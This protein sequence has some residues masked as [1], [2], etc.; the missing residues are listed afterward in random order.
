[1]QAKWTNLRFYPENMMV[2]YYKL[3]ILMM[4][5][6]TISLSCSMILFSWNWCIIL[7]CKSLNSDS[8]QAPYS[9]EENNFQMECWKFSWVSLER[10]S[11]HPRACKI[12]S[13]EPRNIRT[14]SSR[15]ALVQWW[16]EECMEK[17]PGRA[18][19][20]GCGNT[21]YTEQWQITCMA[22]NNFKR[23]WHHCKII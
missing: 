19:R 20:R 11:C 10:S 6:T 2:D 5:P 17:R 12:R 16:R 8:N 1:M 7:Q 9:S 3:K 18:P 15:E 4:K 23:M 14:C 21:A 13:S 22:K